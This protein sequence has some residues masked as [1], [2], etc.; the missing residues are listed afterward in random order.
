[1]AETAKTIDATPSSGEPLVLLVDD[2]QRSARLLA[3]LL[4]TDG[5]RVEVALDGAEAVSRLSRPPLP[6]AIIT[7]LRMPYVDG[8]AVA[9]YAKSLA[10]TMPIIFLTS[11]PELVAGRPEFKNVATEIHTKPIDYGAFRGEM[12]GLLARA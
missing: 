2:D 12:E 4:T 9:R 11:Y 8:I 7:D 1:M 6:R 3:R 10:P 5:Y